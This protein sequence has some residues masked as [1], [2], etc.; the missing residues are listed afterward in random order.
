[1][2]EIID[3]KLNSRDTVDLVQVTDCHLYGDPEGA[4]KGAVTRR[5]L[6]AVLAAIAAEGGAAA[7]LATGDLTQDGEEE[8]YRH[9]AARLGSLAMPAFCMPGNHDDPRILARELVGPG[10]H[11]PARVLAGAWQIIF[12]DSTLPGDNDGALGPG[13]LARLDAALG[14]APNR[15]A[16]VVLHHP[17]VPIRGVT[18]AP[19][20]LADAAAFFAVLAR[21]PQA[22]A[23]LFGHIHQPYE[24]IRGPL[25]IIGSPATCLQFD[26]GMDP[27]RP[28]RRP[29]AGSACCPKAR[30]R[31]P[32]AGCPRACTRAI[33]A[34]PRRERRAGLTR[35]G[36]HVLLP[37]PGA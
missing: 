14:A 9:L 27:S 18:S 15:F 20:S 36:G 17:P 22:R 7:L 32:S 30:W 12:L 1:M 5:T 37:R 28:C 6:D 23:V 2:N 11:Q 10:V 25:Q 35:R 29:I 26:T 8:A 3:L 16:L 19:T 31:A 21:H 34:A 24:A 4:L 13:G 33:R